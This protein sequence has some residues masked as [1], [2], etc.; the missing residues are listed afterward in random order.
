MEA[1]ISI[2][3]WYL[4]EILRIT[5]DNMASPEVLAAERLLKWLHERKIQ[6]TAVKQIQ[7][8][9]P[10]ALREKKEIEHII[11]LLE[12]HG[13]LVPVQGGCPV[14]MGGDKKSFARQAWKVI[15]AVPDKDKV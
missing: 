5:H 11:A 13:W 10:N 6:T 3:N 15:Y 2:S 14:L 7:Q 8:F 4:D 9:G 1:G 12:K